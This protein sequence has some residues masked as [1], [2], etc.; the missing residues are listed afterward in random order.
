MRPERRCGALAIAC[1]ASP[2][3]ISCEGT[4][5]A[6]LASASSSVRIASSSRY[7]IA[8]RRAARRACSTVEAATAKRACPAYS[9]TPSANSGSPGNTGP[10]SFTPGTSSAVTTATTP[11]AARTSS[12]SRR[13]ISAWACV[14]RP[15]AA[16][17]MPAGSG[18]SSTYRASP[19]TCFAAESW[20][21]AARTPP[22][23][24][25]SAMAHLELEDA[26]GGRRRVRLEVELGQ[27][28]L[29]GEQAV[30][31]ACPHVRDGREFPRQRLASAGDGRLGPWPPAQRL[32][33]LP[34]PRG[35]C[36]HAAVRDADIRHPAL[37]E[38]HAEGAEQRRDVLIEPLGDLV[39]AELLPWLRQRYLDHLDELA[40]LERGLAIIEIEVLERQSPPRRALAQHQLGAECDQRGHRIAVGERRADLEMAVGHLEPAQLL[41]RADVDQRV[42]IAVLLGHPQAY[43]GAAGEQTGIRELLAQ[44]REIVDP[45]RR[46]VALAVMGEGEPV[47]A[48]ERVQLSD[49][50][51]CAG[52]ELIV[53]A[54]LV[55]AARG[56]DDGAVA[57]AAAEITGKHVED[58][59]SA[60]R[61]LR[62]IEREQGHHEAGRAEP[63][64]RAVG[65]DHGLL[66]GMQRAVRPAQV[67]DRD[68]LP[69]VES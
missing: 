6:C 11:G 56:V 5:V 19:E 41:D 4:T 28:V 17:S 63:A 40:S 47:V 68:Q 36:R 57:G 43:V 16:Y 30:S 42:Q 31:S 9:T 2:R 60:R 55:H 67:L 37:I 23:I 22:W 44:R 39:A 66:D 8:A 50:L 64:L 1:S 27:Q 49:R 24:M 29:R 65:F 25:L 59:L 20:G 10:M 69:A 26:G 7:S 15:T 21:T 52:A 53:I 3:R 18:R 45:P 48:A 32:F 14:L 38:L 35:D 33:A 62:M 13:T 51:C 46:E 34:C 12:R 58:P 61:R 54:Q